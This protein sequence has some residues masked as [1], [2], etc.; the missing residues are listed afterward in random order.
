MPLEMENKPIEIVC[1][2]DGNYVM[3]TGVMLHSLFVNNMDESINV[4]LLHDGIS[5]DQI[6]GLKDIVSKHGGKITFYKVDESKFSFFPIGHEYQSKHA[7]LSLATYYRLFMTKILP[8]NIDRVIYLDGDILV[9]SSIRGLWETDISGKAMAGVPDTYNNIP[10]HYNRL[11]YPQVCG[12]VNCGVLLMNLEYWRAHDVTR[13]FIDYVKLY[14][15]RLVCHDQDVLNYLFRN[16]KVILH[17]KYNMLNEYFFDLRYNMI[18]WEY[19]KQM[20]EGQENPVIVHF[21]C[22]PKPWYKNCRHP[23]KLLFDRFKA[24]TPW[25]DVKQK[26]WTE[27]RYIIERLCIKFV[28]LL[29]LRG[30]EYI[31]DNRYSKKLRIKSGNV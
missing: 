5:A 22:I 4:H 7:G 17:L 31:V 25:R 16:D 11:R 29:G 3:P 23:Y 19:E 1:S 6:S 18:S 8:E 9:T 10:A 20:L 26:R 15:E 12:Y 28:V 2:T 24:A 21:T 13:K 27:A 30:Q 14:P